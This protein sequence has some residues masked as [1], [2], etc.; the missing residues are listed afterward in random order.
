M[1]RVERID[2]LHLAFARQMRL[3]GT[4]PERLLW[5]RLRGRRVGGF[6]FR[7]QHPLGP[8]VL[9][10]HCIEAK[11]AIEVDGGQ[12]HEEPGRA[13]DE[14]RTTFLRERGIEVI[15]FT[16]LEVL[17]ERDRVLEVIL[18]TLLARRSR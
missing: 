14:E 11:L 1:S 16:N 5:S 13:H 10:F 9:D 4:D 3:A 15:R 12:H 17:R 6:K 7:R 8:Y 18:R 2:P